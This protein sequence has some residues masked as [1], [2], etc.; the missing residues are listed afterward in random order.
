MTSQHTTLTQP[1]IDTIEAAKVLNLAPNTLR[2]WRVK[3]IGP[4]F[5]RLGS[6]TIRY[7]R[8]DLA[9][10]INQRTNEGEVA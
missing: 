7:R 3:G 10:W 8:E 1:L 4:E 9:A 5:V 6:R 2:I